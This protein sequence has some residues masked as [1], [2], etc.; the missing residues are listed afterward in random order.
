M[1]KIKTPGIGNE[2]FKIVFDVLFT[3]G[4]LLNEELIV[5]STEKT[6]GGYV[7]KVTTLEDFYHKQFL[8]KYRQYL[9]F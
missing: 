3:R 9:W 4:D 5:I 8:I 7:S 1:G 6:V 2:T